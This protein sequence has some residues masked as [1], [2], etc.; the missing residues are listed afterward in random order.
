MTDETSH[1]NNPVGCATLQNIVENAAV[2][3]SGG[4]SSD[5]VYTTRL[6]NSSDSRELNPSDRWINRPIDV[7]TNRLHIVRTHLVQ[8]RGRLYYRRRVPEALREVVGKKEIWR[9]LGTDSPTV[10]KRRAVSV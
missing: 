6:H 1:P 9:S 2:L 10:A 3:P 8:Q 4:P 7:Y 5:D